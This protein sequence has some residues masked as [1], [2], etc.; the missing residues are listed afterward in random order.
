MLQLIEINW[1][2]FDLCEKIAIRLVI[3]HEISEFF[4]LQLF[5]LH[6]KGIAGSLVTLVN[7]SSSWFISYTFNFLMTWSSYGNKFCFYFNDRNNLQRIEFGFV[8]MIVVGVDFAGT[9]FVYACICVI[10]I[11]FILKLVPETKG[12]T[13][14]DIHATVH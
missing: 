3:W 12:R 6:L 10:S 5:P 4:E 11:I 9:F 13:L 7:W 1:Q 8:T 2:Y 14:E